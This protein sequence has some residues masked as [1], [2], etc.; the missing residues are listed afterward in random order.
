MLSII[1]NLHASRAELAI[2]AVVVAVMFGSSLVFGFADTPSPAHVASLQM[3]HDGFDLLGFPTDADS[4]ALSNNTYV[5]TVSSLGVGIINFTDPQNPVSVAEML[6]DQRAYS[7]ST[8]AVGTFTIDHHAYALAADSQTLQI[9]N[10]TDPASPDTVSSIRNGQDNAYIL[11]HLSPDDAGHVWDTHP[12]ARDLVYDW[13]D[14]SAAEIVDT[15]SGPYALVAS[16]GDDT[17]HVMDLSNPSFPVLVARLQDGVGG[18]YALGNPVDIDSFAALDG[19]YAIVVGSGDSAIQIIDMSNPLSPVASM[20]HGQGGEYSVSRYEHVETFSV[21]NRPYALLSGTGGVLAVDLG[22]PTNPAVAGTIQD[23]YGPSAWPVGIFGDENHVYAL[24]ASPEGVLVMDVGDPTNPAVAGTI[25]VD[26][27]ETHFASMVM[28]ESGDHAY[29]M[30]GSYSDRSVRVISLANPEAPYQALHAAAGHDSLFGYGFSAV[31][32]EILHV[33]NRTYALLPDMERD[34][35]RVIDVTNPEDP[36]HI[37]DIVGGSGDFAALSKP[38]HMEIFEADNA[39]YALVSGEY[40]AILV[41]DL[42][43]PYS[44]VLAA[45]VWDGSGGIETFRVHNKTYGL[46]MAGNAAHIMDMTEPETALTVS[47]SRPLE[48]YLDINHVG[49]EVFSA[50]G[51]L[52]A[53]MVQDFGPGFQLM[54]ITDTMAPEFLDPVEMEQRPPFV[55]STPTDMEIFYS[56]DRPYALV[57]GYDRFESSGGTIQIADLARPSNPTYIFTMAGGHGQFDALGLPLDAEIFEL[58]ERTYALVLHYDGVSGVSLYTLDITNPD[59]PEPGP[60]IPLED[61]SSPADAEVFVADGVA[62]IVLADPGR[63]QIVSLG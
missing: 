61:G 25:N 48:G 60:A 32:M 14:A 58:A 19:T 34:T 22:D 37:R 23:G 4:F 31:D 2:Q 1:S 38:L 45:E 50:S 27:H 33:S 40:G 3:A 8:H 55:F 10:V 39:A 35:I 63:L 7:W 13:D 49:P 62:Y 5:V 52:Y 20:R 42:A 57:A 56:Y 53:V 36:R 26:L 54:D 15:P 21:S 51:R 29:A 44:P 18:F 59:D 6:K 41:L 16:T 30:L 46:V 9:I 28:F 12:G 17:I 47:G 43:D 11:R 24:V